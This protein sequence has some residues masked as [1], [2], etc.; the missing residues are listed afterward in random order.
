MDNFRFNFITLSMIEILW[1]LVICFV[2]RYKTKITDFEILPVMDRWNVIFDKTGTHYVF[3]RT[4]VNLAPAPTPSKTE[5][6][7]APEQIWNELRLRLKFLKLT[8]ASAPVNTFF[9]SRA[10]K[11]YR[12]RLQLQQKK[13]LFRLRLFLREDWRLKDWS[14]SRSRSHKILDVAPAS[15][16]SE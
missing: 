14:R 12:I 15:G 3:F 7:P 2:V 4:N 10:N 9:Q 6:A 5:L 1:N 11:F 8:L 16:S 13:S